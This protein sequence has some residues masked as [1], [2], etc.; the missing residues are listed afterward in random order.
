M[1]NFCFY[2]LLNS[3]LKPERIRSTTKE[4]C[5]NIQCRYRAA[6]EQFQCPFRAVPQPACDSISSQRSWLWNF[7]FLLENNFRAVAKKKG[8]DLRRALT[9]TLRWP[10]NAATRR[11]IMDPLSN[12]QDPLLL[13][14]LQIDNNM[15]PLY[16]IFKMY[17]WRYFFFLLLLLL[18]AIW[19]WLMWERLS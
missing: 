4:T 6:A 11:P 15:K 8:R 12:A 18:L 10:F 14:W 19:P 3:P 17:K 2:S 7:L 5:H 13:C 16:F 9:L 1:S